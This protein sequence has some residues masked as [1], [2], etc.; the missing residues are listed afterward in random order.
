MVSVRT[1][2]SKTCSVRGGL[3]PIFSVG[4]FHDGNELG[5]NSLSGKVFMLKRFT[6]RPAKELLRLEE[7]IVVGLAVVDVKV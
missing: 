5:T 7:I 4:T 3:E 2:V 6:P 1:P